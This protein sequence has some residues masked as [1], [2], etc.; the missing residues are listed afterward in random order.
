MG[1]PGRSLA[2]LVLMAAA[3]TLLVLGTAGEGAE[4][5]LPEITVSLEGEDTEQVAFP[6]ETENDLLIF[7]GCLTFS[8][9][10]WPPGTSVVIEMSIEMPDLDEPWQFSIDPP[11]HTFTA[12]ESQAFSARVTVPA[13]LPATVTIGHPLEFTASTENILIY[14]VTSD[15]ARVTVAQYYRMSRYFS[16]EPIKV[17]QGEVVEFNFTVVNGGNGVDTFVFEVTNE[18]EMLFAG[19]TIPPINPRRLVTGEDANIRITMQAAADAREGQFKL[20]LTIR[21]EGSSQD[22][23]YDNPVTSGIEWNVLVEPSL[24]QTIWANIEYIILGVVV[25]IVVAAVLVILRG[26]RMAAEEEEEEEEE[27]PPPKKRRKKRPP[28]EAEGDDE[29]TPPP[30]RK[31]P[32]P[33]RDEGEPD[34]DR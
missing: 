29:A 20:N 24:E 4:A 11:T 33:R 27:T 17:E 16:T 13:G 25:L 22:P 28:E 34:E 7:E 2:L 26:R 5:Q 31:R 12:S 14:D 21:S 18:A 8:R 3:A 9:P 30:R 6:T 1:G 32:P 23:N 10:F 15:T 19:L